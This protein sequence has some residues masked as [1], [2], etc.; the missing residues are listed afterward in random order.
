MVYDLYSSDKNHRKSTD[1]VR[2]KLTKIAKDDGSGVFSGNSWNYL[3]PPD[4]WLVKAKVNGEV[5]H[6]RRRAYLIDDLMEATGNT[7]YIEFQEIVNVNVKTGAIDFK[8]HKIP[9][10]DYLTIKTFTPPYPDGVKRWMSSWIFGDDKRGKL[11]VKLTSQ[12]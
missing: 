1:H 10:D 11:Y 3:L 7:K 5:L 9:V 12:G 6:G 4:F 8:E 2:V